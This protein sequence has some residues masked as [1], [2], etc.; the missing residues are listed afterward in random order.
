MDADAHETRRGTAYPEKFGGSFMTVSFFQ[1]AWIYI[2]AHWATIA[3]LLV[4][5]WGYASPT[6]IDYVHNHPH[7]TFWFGLVVVVITFFWKS[8]FKYPTPADQVKALEAGK[9]V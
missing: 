2:V 4:A 7:L 6:V 5:V 1:K 3:A 9:K 8:P